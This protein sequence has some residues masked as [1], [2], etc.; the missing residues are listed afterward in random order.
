MLQVE[1]LKQLNHGSN[2]EE[3]VRLFEGGQV[4]F[5][6]EAL[7]EYIKA[8]SR[9]DRLDNSRLMGLLQVG[10]RLACGG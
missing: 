2:A 8:L 1:H 5:T 9:M 4:A 7:G 10:G 6:Q 3:V